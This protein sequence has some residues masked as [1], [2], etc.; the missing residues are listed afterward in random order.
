MEGIDEVLQEGFKMSN[1]ERAEISTKEGVQEQDS[2]LGEGC[3]CYSSPASG[4]LRGSCL[5]CLYLK[6]RLGHPYL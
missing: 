5:V 2:G 1:I 4:S 6:G 3:H